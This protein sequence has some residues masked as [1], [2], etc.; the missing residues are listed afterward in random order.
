MPMFDPIK[1]PYRPMN[2]QDFIELE[3]MQQERQAKIDV[4]F[5]ACEDLVNKLQTAK[6]KERRGNPAYS[7]YLLARIALGLDP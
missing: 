4:A 3:R 1:F 7:S 2:E 6:A 5:K